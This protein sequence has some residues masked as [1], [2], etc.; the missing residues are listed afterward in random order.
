MADLECDRA[1][2]SAPGVGAVQRLRVLG[3]GLASQDRHERRFGA[4]YQR[5]GQPVST[6]PVPDAIPC[7]GRSPS[8]RSGRVAT[9]CRRF[10][11]SP[12]PEPRIPGYRPGR[13]KSCACPA[14]R[15]RGDAFLASYH[16]RRYSGMIPG[17]LFPSRA[18]PALGLHLRSPVAI[19][20][21][22]LVRAA[23]RSPVGVCDGP[24]P[25]P[26][27]VYLEDI[28]DTAHRVDE[29]GVA[30]VLL[31][32]AAQPVDVDI[33]RAGFAGVVVA[34]LLEQLV[35]R[36]D[37]ARVAEQEGQQLKAFGL[38]GNVA[39]SRSQSVDPGRPGRGPGRRW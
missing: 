24:G 21:D 10:H 15:R 5:R 3:L 38:V 12:E 4:V 31:D 28:A 35:T 27:S 22:R 7:R 26:T 17:R 30:E 18:G 23:S 8:R 1:A 11:S 9:R 13:C 2:A 16:P 34:R 36:E 6:F 29:R 33:D 14:S 39:P 32:P 37:L 20:R 25:P 19:S